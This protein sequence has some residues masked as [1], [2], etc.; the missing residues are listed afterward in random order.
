MKDCP[1]EDSRRE[2]PVA[3]A[4]RTV[5]GVPYLYPYQRLVIS[6]ILDAAADPA[7]IP[8]SGHGEDHPGEHEESAVSPDRLRQVV[9]LP[10]GYGKSLCFQL[11]SV[12]LQGL[13]LAV[14]P[15]R[16]LMADQARRLRERGLACAV[17]QGGLE[18]E[19]RRRS[20]EEIRTG[21]ARIALANPEILRTGAVLSLLRTVGVAHAVVDEA[22]CVAE[23]GDDFRPAYQDLGDILRSLD[24]Q[25]VTAFTATAS[26]A[27]LARTAEV[28]FGDAP[29][30]VI[31]GDPDRP[32]LRYACAP[33]LSRAHTL[34]RLVRSLPKP[35][36]VFC[37]SRAGAQISAETLA[38]ALGS[39]EV[40]F[41]HAG[42]TKAERT[43]V[44]AWYLPSR[45]GIL[46]A[47]CAFGMGIDKADIRSVVHADPPPSVESYLQ[48]S[49]RAGRDGKPSQAV[50]IFHPQDR[51]RLRLEE[52]PV[53]RQRLRAVLEY[54]EET[55]VCRREI[56]LRL[57]GTRV[58]SCSGCDVCSGSAAPGPEGRDELLRFA[59]ANPGR[60]SVSDA[61]RRLTGRSD[62]CAW[63]GSLS[64]WD[65][66]HAAEALSYLAGNGDILVPRRGPWKGRVRP[67][68]R[69]G[70]K[71]LSQKSGY[72]SGRPVPLRVSHT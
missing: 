64:D 27:I 12:L 39:R 17:L 69:R 60:C 21:K 10:T 31:S 43:A 56:L 5:F 7:A 72:L 42:M 44:E 41:Y 33:T 67:A 54:A 61:A 70:A 71:R 65:P 35:L 62:P 47:T 55:A 4:A 2:D 6:N 15:L 18:E 50:L 66:A 68:A 28:L 45:D 48:E 34:S 14:Y 53:R 16:S 1:E 63:S 29:W 9:L 52:D 57:L 19:E 49:G 51:D 30:R 8:P 58:D 3:A 13:T 20:F 59:A 38:R 36:L 24:P 25:A 23:W 22:H 11:P 40:R 26:P 46:T 37:A 32:N